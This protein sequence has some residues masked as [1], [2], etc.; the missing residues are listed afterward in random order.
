MSAYA[1]VFTRIHK[2]LLFLFYFIFPFFKISY[3]IL[4]SQLV[5]ES[6]KSSI[7]SSVMINVSKIWPIILTHSLNLALVYDPSK[8]N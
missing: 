5:S 4:G 8:A 3:C 1:I 7:S 6:L 2:L